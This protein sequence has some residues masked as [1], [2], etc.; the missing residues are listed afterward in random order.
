[1]NGNG[2]PDSRA[3]FLDGLPDHRRALALAVELIGSA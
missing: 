3:L 1:V 2:A